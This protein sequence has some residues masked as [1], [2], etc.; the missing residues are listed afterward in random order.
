MRPFNIMSVETISGW[1][2]LADLTESLTA[3]GDGIATLVHPFD[4]WTPE[5]EYAGTE[6]MTSAQAIEYQGA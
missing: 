6:W 2:L 5:G 1:Q 4:F 3:I